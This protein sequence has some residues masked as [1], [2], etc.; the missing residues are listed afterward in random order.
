MI[1]L[2]TR[3]HDREQTSERR[4]QDCRLSGSHRGL[5]IHGDLA[6]LSG[7]VTWL[8]IRDGSFGQFPPPVERG[9]VVLFWVFGAAGSAYAFGM[10]L[11]TLALDGD[12]FVAREYALRGRRESR[13]P[14]TSE[15]RPIMRKTRDAEGDDVYLVEVKTPDG[16][17]IAVGGSSDM[18]CS[19]ALISAMDRIIDRR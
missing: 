11:V 1:M 3:C 13:F 6:H 9:I 10:P 2:S 12:T 7:I 5:D 17:R 8:Y 14:V 15:S 4:N 18:E 16:R 19:L